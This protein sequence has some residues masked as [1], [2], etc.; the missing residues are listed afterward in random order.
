MLSPLQSYFHYSRGE[1]R[2]TVVLMII[3]VVLISFYFISGVLFS[4]AGM[5]SPDVQKFQERIASF[6]D[7]KKSV[8]FTD[9]IQYFMFDPNQISTEGWVKL[10]FS[11]KQAEA[12]E[13]YKASGAEFKVKKDLLKL[14]MVDEYTYARLAPYIDLPDDFSDN[15]NHKMMTAQ[16]K[17]KVV[18]AIVLQESE[19]PV[20]EG[21][22]AYEGVHYTKKK[23]LYQYC[24]LPFE[25]KS[26][27]EKRLTEMN[28]AGGKIIALS[29][30]KGYYPIL[31]K[32]DHSVDESVSPDKENLLI[33]LNT[34]D[35]TALKKLVGIGSAYANRIVNYRDA[36]GGFINLNQLQEVYGLKQE[37]INNILPNLIIS[38]TEIVKIDINKASIDELKAH[39]YIDWKVANSIFQIRNNYG[40]FAGIDGILKSDLIDDALFQKIKPYIEAK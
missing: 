8:S 38:E 35:T 30:T 9:S 17:S 18:Y 6:E 27:A 22:G 26:E 10:G 36:L 31:N 4:F 33:D 40:K 13:N 5:T 37:T 23:G 32:E 11:Q 29:S 39:P 7:Q 2:G 34:A 14:F 15:G 16:K 19:N 21:F 24:I 1:R 3:I 12:I 28:I 25:D 20:Y